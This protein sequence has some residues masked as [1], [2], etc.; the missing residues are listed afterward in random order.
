LLLLYHLRVLD[1][2]DAGESAAAP[3]TKDPSP[4]NR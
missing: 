4:T 2:L 1:S 3:L